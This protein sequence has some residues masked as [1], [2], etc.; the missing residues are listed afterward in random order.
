MIFFNN[1][2]NFG[3]IVIQ[4]IWNTYYLLYDLDDNELLQTFLNLSFI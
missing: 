2:K 1:F 4:T 3:I